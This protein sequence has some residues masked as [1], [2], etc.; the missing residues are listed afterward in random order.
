M[1]HVITHFMSKLQLP[2]K[3]Q[4]NDEEDREQC[5]FSVK[6]IILLSLIWGRGLTVG[7]V[8]KH[9]MEEDCGRGG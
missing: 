1:T 2:F 6:L 4:S 8:K 7:I 5:K 9:C 3:R